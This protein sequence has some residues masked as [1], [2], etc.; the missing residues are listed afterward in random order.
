M[1]I[2]I[3]ALDNGWQALS[4][5]DNVEDAEKMM[6]V[7]QGENPD[8]YIRMVKHVPRFYAE[9]QK[10][11]ECSGGTRTYTHIVYVA[12]Y[13]P[14]RSIKACKANFRAKVRTL[15]EFNDP[16]FKI[17]HEYVCPERG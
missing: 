9:Y 15:P 1:K 11:I 12:E 16:T 17:R 6:D 7:V 14:E 13:P 10:P 8:A 4:E 3:E 2:V 5:H